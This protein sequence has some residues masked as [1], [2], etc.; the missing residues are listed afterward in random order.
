MF[1]NATFGW[2][3]VAL[4]T[5]LTTAWA[6]LVFVGPMKLRSVERFG[7]AAGALAFAALTLWVGAKQ[8]V[9]L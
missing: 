1:P 7:L 2:S 6:A 5:A 3:D 9:V 8:L 4:G